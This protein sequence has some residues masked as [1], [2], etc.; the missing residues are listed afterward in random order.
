MGWSLTSGGNIQKT[1]LDRVACWKAIFVRPR[2]SGGVKCGWNWFGMGPRKESVESVRPVKVVSWM[3]C[4]YCMCLLVSILPD[5]DTFVM[6]TFYCPFILACFILRI[7][8]FVLVFTF[9]AKNNCSKMVELVVS[10]IS[11]PIFHEAVWNGDW[12]AVFQCSEFIW[13]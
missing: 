6:R 5:A 13:K 7:P 4:A 3:V 8:F 10:V 12:V 1:S 11:C 2:R 9:K